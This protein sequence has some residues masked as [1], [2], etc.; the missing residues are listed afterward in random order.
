M[1][2]YRNVTGHIK[3]DGY[4]D[5]YVENAS[6]AVYL[7]KKKQRAETKWGFRFRSGIWKSGV[8]E[9]G[10]W[11]GGIWLDGTWKEGYVSSPYKDLLE[12]K[13]RNTSY[14]Y[15]NVD[16]PKEVVKHIFKKTGLQKEMYYQAQDYVETCLRH[17]KS[18]VTDLNYNDCDLYRIA[19][20]GAVLEEKLLFNWADEIFDKIHEIYK[21]KHLDF[22]KSGNELSDFEITGGY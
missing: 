10:F 19:N 21:I 13:E 20:L 1:R 9:R 14:Y 3:Y 11:T 22:L 8:W 4:V 12:E 15:T 17:N 6:F 18:P 5:A 16:T 7:C 2:I